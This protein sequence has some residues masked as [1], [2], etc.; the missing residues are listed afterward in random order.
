MLKKME[1]TDF[2]YLGVIFLFFVITVTVF[3]Y[4]TGF[5][6]QNV[7]KIFI[8]NKGEDVQGLDLARYLLVQKK[9][10]LPVNVVDTNTVTGTVTTPV[11][12]TTPTTP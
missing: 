5:I 9:L 7:N 11:M 2:I 8:Q 12:T 10:S 1:T 6:V 3:F 4:S